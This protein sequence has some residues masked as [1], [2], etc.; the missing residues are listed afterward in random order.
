MAAKRK[1]VG[2]RPKKTVGARTE[3][4]LLAFT[5]EELLTLR[6]VATENGETLSSIAGRVTMAP[7]GR[8]LAVRSRTLHVNQD[9]PLHSCRPSVDVLFRSQAMERTATVNSERETGDIP[10]LTS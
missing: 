5:P 1:N 3:R 2:G 8:H 7:V 9:P 10:Q 6:T 4:F